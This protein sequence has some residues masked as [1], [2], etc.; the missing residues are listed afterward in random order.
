M[1]SMNYKDYEEQM[2][3]VIKEIEKT[4]LNI[5]EYVGMIE[6]AL[7]KAC[8]ILSSDLQ[9]VDIDGDEKLVKED[10]ETWKAWCMQDD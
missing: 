5:T 4:T 10:K 9:K 2:N 6:R 8:E 1:I 7:D 3:H